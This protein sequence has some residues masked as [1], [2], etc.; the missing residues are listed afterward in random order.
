[1]QRPENTAVLGMNR[2]DSLPQI[3]KLKEEVKYLK[4]ILHVK[5]QGGGISELVYRLKALQTEN[6]SLKSQLNKRILQTSN[7]SINEHSAGHQ[8]GKNKSNAPKTEPSEVYLLPR[9][10][11]EGF[12]LSERSAEPEP[13]TADRR[14]KFDR[15]FASQQL[16]PSIFAMAEKRDVSRQ[17]QKIA[18]K[19]TPQLKLVDLSEPASGSLRDDRDSGSYYPQAG[20]QNR[21][22]ASSPPVR[23]SKWVL[24]DSIHAQLINSVDGTI[25][26]SPS[27]PPIRVPSDGKRLVM[28][29]EE[30]DLDDDKLT[31]KNHQVDSKIGISRTAAASPSHMRQMSRS[32]QGSKPGITEFGN[33]ERIS[34]S[35]LISN[36]HS[37]RRL[38]QHPNSSHQ[39]DSNVWRFEPPKSPFRGIESH[40]KK[41][42][43]LKLV[44][45][46]NELE[47]DLPSDGVRYPRPHNPQS[48]R[49][50]DYLSTELLS[51]DS[52]RSLQSKI[53]SA[54]LK[55]PQ[56]RNLGVFGTAS[57]ARSP[58]AAGSSNI[59]PELSKVLWQVDHSSNKPRFAINTPN[60]VVPRESLLE[61]VDLNLQKIRREM[62]KLRQGE[63][64]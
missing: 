18:F 13:S 12:E 34:N 26:E 1:M 19:P 61:Q 64:T 42:Q 36:S 25:V 24:E 50:P 38:R 20:N 31:V 57:A 27:L 21:H 58:K 33:L 14:S 44:S 45:R 56:D 37:E 4:N 39:Q 6:Q 53:T 29:D 5:S 11:K 32:F 16:R 35:Q 63:N 52:A 47:A 3:S 49:H 28:S 9:Y 46:L 15:L 59:R 55:P 7:G 23:I 60:R 30:L 10:P 40:D 2:P 48:R 8:S 51:N 43:L 22:R 62:S 41:S 54:A 17:V